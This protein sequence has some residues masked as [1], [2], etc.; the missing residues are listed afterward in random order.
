MIQEKLSF[1]YIL[2][3]CNGV[4]YRVELG[5]RSLRYKV[6]DDC[7]FYVYTHVRE[8]E[9][10]LFGFDE[11]GELE[12]FEMLLE[13]SG[14][15]PKVALSLITKLG[16][17]EVID[18]ILQKNA[19]ELKVTGVGIKT[20][21]KIVLELGDK[22]KKKGFKV[23]GEMRESQMRDKKFLKKLEEVKEALRSLGYS[24]AD[25]KGGIGKAK[26][27]EKTAQMPVEGLIKYL[28]SKM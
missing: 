26:F 27:N 24:A 6:S 28:L 14:V 20:A 2:L 21:D 4:G 9:I 22:L 16:A 17:K 12:L 25:I 3:D 11:V 18:S 15:G 1:D 5:E 13:V 7:E 19:Y 8:N 23:S 10:R